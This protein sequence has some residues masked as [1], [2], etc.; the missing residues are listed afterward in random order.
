MNRILVLSPHTDDAELG[1]GGSII[2]FLEEGKDVRWLVF[3]T[4]EESLP[5]GLPSD[6]LAAEFRKVVEHLG[7]RAGQYEIGDY[8]VRHLHEKRQ[9]ILEQLVR[10]RGEFQPDLV[11]IPSTRDY[12]QDHQVVAN[13]AI[14]AFKTTASIICYEMP[15]NQVEFASTL[16]VRLAERHIRRK[17]DLLDFYKS[18]QLRRRDYMTREYIYGLAKVRGIQCSADYAEAFEV[19]RW[20]A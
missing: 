20:M 16:F 12:H 7:L 5:A 11:V 6:T 9:D 10:V 4:A 8:R 2:R 17:F 15:W 19:V 18:Q 14:R 13:E 3:S 1:A